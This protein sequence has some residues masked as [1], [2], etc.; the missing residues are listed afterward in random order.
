MTASKRPHRWLRW[1]NQVVVAQNG[2]P[3]TLVFVALLI[4]S[5]ALMTPAIERFSPQ[6]LHQPTRIK[7]VVALLA[8]AVLGW[9][10]YRLWRL[11]RSREA[12]AW[13]RKGI[14]FHKDHQYLAALTA[15]DRALDVRP[16]YV[17]ALVNKG[18][19]LTLLRRYDE[20]LVIFDQALDIDAGA[21]DIWRK[22]AVALHALG[23]NIEADESEHQAGKLER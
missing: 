12:H 9:L 13:N 2:W 15:F 11:A 21:A 20:A 1:L 18:A 23:R 3:F 17:S 7:L 4:M 16:D 14:A 6:V 5:A 10:G 19:A 22:K 8:L